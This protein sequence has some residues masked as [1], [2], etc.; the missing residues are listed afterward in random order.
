MWFGNNRRLLK[1]R[2]D[3][4]G[5]GGT[6]SFKPKRSVRCLVAS[7]KCSA[8]KLNIWFIVYFCKTTGF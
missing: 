4:G 2:N 8:G 7:E 1:R 6:E 3:V 5:E